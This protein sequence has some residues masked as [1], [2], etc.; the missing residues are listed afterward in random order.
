ME[1]ELQLKNQIINIFSLK[2]VHRF[3]LMLI[4]PWGYVK[5]F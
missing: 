5:S 3:L 2:G 4:M 1:L